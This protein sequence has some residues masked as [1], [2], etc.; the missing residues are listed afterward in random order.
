MNGVELLRPLSRSA[1]G[2]FFY[3]K[4]HLGVVKMLFGAPDKDMGGFMKLSKRAKN[5]LDYSKILIP[6]WSFFK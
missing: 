1:Q 2:C 4:L 5:A 3:G 6:Q